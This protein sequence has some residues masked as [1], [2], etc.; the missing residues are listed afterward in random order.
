M[1]PKQTKH[2]LDPPFS[3][4]VLCGERLP[5]KQDTPRSCIRETVGAAGFF[6]PLDA[7]RFLYHVLLVKCTQFFK[8]AVN[9][10]SATAFKPGLLLNHKALTFHTTACV[11]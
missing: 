8:E 2:A 3:Q 1:R 7:E 4:C 10:E 11:T 6:G 9:T 5:H